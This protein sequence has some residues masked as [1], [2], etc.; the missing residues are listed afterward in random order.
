MNRIKK[1]INSPAPI[2]RGQYSVW[3][4]CLGVFLMVHFIHLLP[5]GVELFTQ[6]GVFGASTSP[7]MGI[8]PNPL[9]VFDT[10]WMIGLLLFTGVLCSAL[11]AIGKL[12]R[13]AGLLIALILSWLFARNPLIANP[14]MPVVGWMLIFHAFVPVGCY[15]SRDARGK[16]RDLIQWHLPKGLWICAWV[17]LAIAYSYSGFTKLTSPSWVD[18]SAIELVLN[19]PLARDH[20]LRDLLLALPEG[21]LTGLTWLIMWI[22]V[23]FILFALWGPSRF[24]VWSIMLA[25]QAGFLIFLNFADLTLPMFL[26]HALTFDN[27]WLSRHDSQNASRPDSL[28][29]DA[30]APIPELY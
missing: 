10:P 5:F 24:I 17:M 12:H 19:N 21:I 8:I 16:T 18:G 2:T 22:E 15:G 30:T 28:L 11:F 1:Y 3:R 23:L 26:I 27:R 7:L 9:N 4:L 29:S 14:S 25:V 6:Q 20:A 13:P